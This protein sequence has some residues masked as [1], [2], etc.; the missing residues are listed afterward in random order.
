MLNGFCRNGNPLSL[1][2]W[3]DSIEK[4]IESK[5]KAYRSRGD[6]YFFI[7]DS[8]TSSDP[9]INKP[10]PSHCMKGTD[11]AK[12]IDTLENYANEENTLTKNTLSITHNTKLIE[13]LEDLNITEIE[14]TG[15]CTDICILFAVYELRIR[16]YKVIVNSKAVLPLKSENQDLFL[17]Y[18]DELLS[19]NI[20]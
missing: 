15:V 8:H 14:V 9:E 1:S 17:N 6:K 19:A 13:R 7:C 12:I 5:I 20:E 18:M 3:T 11:E 4:E 2:D 10:Y 16:G